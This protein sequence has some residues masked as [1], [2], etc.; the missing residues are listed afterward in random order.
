MPIAYL[1]DISRGL[2]RGK[3]RRK[4]AKDVVGPKKMR[5]NSSMDVD[6]EGDDDSDSSENEDDDDDD[7]DDMNV[8]HE[9]I[10]GLDYSLYEYH[11]SL[12][13]GKGT[14]NPIVHERF[15]GN[16]YEVFIHTS[17]S[18]PDILILWF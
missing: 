4:K 1:L 7:D 10:F 2:G 17:R 14:R 11:K 16:Y 8:E 15:T 6:D 13:N 18:F 3:N 9:Q 5:A 12:H